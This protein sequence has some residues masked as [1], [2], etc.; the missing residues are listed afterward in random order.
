MLFDCVGET[1]GQL[2]PKFPPQSD[3]D[4]DFLMDLKFACKYIVYSVFLD[5]LDYLDYLDRLLRLLR[6]HILLRLLIQF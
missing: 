5:Y 6:L 3:E 4:V 2:L 1:L